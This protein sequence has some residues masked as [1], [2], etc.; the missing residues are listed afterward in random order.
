[1]RCY[2]DI[3]KDKP[4]NYSQL[5]RLMIHREHDLK[6]LRYN[7]QYFSEASG[8]LLREPIWIAADAFELVERLPEDMQF[9]ARLDIERFIRDKLIYAI[10]GELSP[11]STDYSTH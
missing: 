6:V 8:F 2:Y 5:I 3:F 7:F 10:S 4:E 11:D 1:M 9:V